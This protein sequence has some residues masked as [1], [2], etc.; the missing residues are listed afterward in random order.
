MKA[1]F[2]SILGGRAGPG[3][4]LHMHRASC[5]NSSS[6]S[7]PAWKPWAGRA[8]PPSPTPIGTRRRSVIPSQWDCPVVAGGRPSWCRDG[9][10]SR[11]HHSSSNSNC[12]SRRGRRAGQAAAARGAVLYP[13]QLSSTRC[14]AL[15]C[16][17][18]SVVPF[19]AV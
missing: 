13:L 6:S 10:P 19:T 7:S 12:S 8:T 3:C 14:C 15:Y 1:I 9:C 4:L 17:A 11:L 2:S 5:C 16:L 18:P